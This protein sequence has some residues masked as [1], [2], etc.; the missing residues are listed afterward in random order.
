M[1]YKFLF[2]FPEAT[3][4]YAQQEALGEGSNISVALSRA[5]KEVMSRKGIKGKR[6]TKFRLTGVKIENGVESSSEDE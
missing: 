1:K 3:S 2:T 5:T 6:L 4:A